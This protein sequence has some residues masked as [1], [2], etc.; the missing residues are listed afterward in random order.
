[1]INCHLDPCVNESN[2]LRLDGGS[3]LGILFRVVMPILV[4]GLVPTAMFVFLLIWDEF[5]YAL[6]FA[7]TL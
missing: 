5:F 3:R 1:M 4:P 7:S 6:I 2:Y